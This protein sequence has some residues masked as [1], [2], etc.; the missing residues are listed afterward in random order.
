M[1]WCPALLNQ[2]ADLWTHA[3]YQQILAARG[4]AG[5]AEPTTPGEIVFY[6][7]RLAASER[8]RPDGWAEKCTAWLGHDNPFVRESAL[9]NT[10]LPLPAP[11]KTFFAESFA[12]HDFGVQRAA[13]MLARKTRDRGLSQHVVTVFA[14]ATHLGS[15]TRLAMPPGCSA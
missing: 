1:S 7:T 4:A 15:L 10:P 11:F 13:C 9:R 8:F 6:L 5:A 14:G 2:T 3:R 12:D